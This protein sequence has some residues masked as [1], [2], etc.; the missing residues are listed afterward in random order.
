MGSGFRDKLRKDGLSLRDLYF[1][2]CHLEACIGN[3]DLGE[4][5]WLSFCSHL[6]CLSSKQLLFPQASSLFKIHAVSKMFEGHC[7]AFLYLA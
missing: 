3:L 4:K 2:P 7:R 6:R 1:L 5:V